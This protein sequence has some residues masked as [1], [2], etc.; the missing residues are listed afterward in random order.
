MQ[1]KI[2]QL[3]DHCILCGYGRIG[4]HIYEFIKDSFPIL[5]IEKNPTII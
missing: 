2:A 5:I 4:K 1:K 3:K